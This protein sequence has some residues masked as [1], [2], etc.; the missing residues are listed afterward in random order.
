MA[1]PFVSLSTYIGSLTL[2]SSGDKLE[3][4][5]DITLNLPA[6][7]SSCHQGPVAPSLL[8][9]CALIDLTFFPYK[10]SIFLNTP[11]EARELLHFSTPKAK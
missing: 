6:S 8:R 1:V 4:E 5:P 10:L 7:S 11:P 9:I 2:K 3:N